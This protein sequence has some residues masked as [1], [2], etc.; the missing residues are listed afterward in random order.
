MTV[1]RPELQFGVTELERRRTVVTGFHEKPRSDALDQRR[2][3]LLRARRVR[4]PRRRVVLEREPLEGLA[5]DGQLRA[6]RHTRLLGVHGHLQGRGHAQRPVGGRRGPLEDVGLRPDGRNSARGGRIN[7]AVTPLRNRPPSP[8]PTRSASASTS[9]PLAEGRRASTSSTTSTRPPSTPPRSSPAAPTPRARPSCASRRRS[10]SRASPSSR[11]PRATSTGAR[12]E[13]RRGGRAGRPAAVPDRPD[14]VRGR[15]RRRPRERRGDRAQGRPR[16][17]DRRG[18]PDLARGAD[19]ALRHRPDGLLRQL[20]APPADAAR[21]ARR[22]GGQPEPGGPRQARAGSTSNTVLVGFSAGRPHP[23]VVRAMK[24]ARNR[25]AATI[26]IAD[27]TLSEVA[28]LA[29]HRLYYSSNSP[30][31]VRSHRR[32][33]AWSRRWPTAS[34]RWTSPPTRTASRPSG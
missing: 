9:S 20:P 26:A 16:R 14:R 28:K 21:P 27:A 23:L 13:R 25:R 5:A 33:S 19:R 30:A 11:P 7:R 2:L 34:T 29:D 6:Y 22:G 3:L 4:L 17:G 32:C 1:V 15:A 18:R 24:L 8:S 10:A 31:Y 12:A